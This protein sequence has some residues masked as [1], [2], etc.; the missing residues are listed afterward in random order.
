MEIKNY[1]NE[2]YNIVSGSLSDIIAVKA[3]I[4]PLVRLSCKKGD[5]SAVVKTM[6]EDGLVVQSKKDPF[7]SQFFLYVSKSSN[8]INQAKKF[9]NTFTHDGM[10]NDAMKRTIINF[11]K[12]L[13]YPECCTKFLT[14]NMPLIAKEIK[15]KFHP[16]G[17]IDFSFNN[18][19]NSITNHYLSF[20]QSCSYTCPNSRKYLH[21][22]YKAIGKED[23]GF[24]KDLKKHLKAPYLLVF[25]LGLKLSMAWDRR[26]GF[27]FDGEVTKNQIKY[28]DFSFFNTTYPEYDNSKIDDNIEKLK[29]SIKNGNK[30]I[31]END[32]IL[33]LRDSELIIE[34]KNSDT[35]KTSIFNFV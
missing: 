24:Q 19:L 17:D 13:G 6:N 10:S 34:I 20:H 16:R 31:I 29:E 21:D 27:L 22:I 18:T 7:S 11:G 26:Q 23:S 33:I 14:E 15:W 28:N 1:L 30:I 25:N 2:R 4:K 8:I 5:M 9:D 12:F 3:D 32:S 35:F